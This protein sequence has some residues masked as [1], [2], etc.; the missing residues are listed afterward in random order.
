MCIA[1]QVLRDSPLFK[2][3]LTQRDLNTETV[4]YGIKRMCVIGRV[5]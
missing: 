4:F 5:N 3:F 1:S 2:P